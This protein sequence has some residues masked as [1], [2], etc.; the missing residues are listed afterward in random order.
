MGNPK[1]KEMRANRC[2]K[3][4]DAKSV[5]RQEVADSKALRS[6]PPQHGSRTEMVDFTGDA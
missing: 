5:L 4:K 6:L 3:L 2:L 1:K